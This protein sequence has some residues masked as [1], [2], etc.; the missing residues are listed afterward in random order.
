MNLFNPLVDAVDNFGT[1]N[2]YFCGLVHNGCFPFANV[3][4]GYGVVFVFKCLYLRVKILPH[5]SEVVVTCDVLAAE[6]GG[7]EGGMGGVGSHGLVSIV[8][9]LFVSL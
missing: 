1:A 6:D 5:F 7:S 3:E 9:A 8:R 2:V 4:G